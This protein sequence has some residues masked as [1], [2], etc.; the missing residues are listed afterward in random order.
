M[1]REGASGDSGPPES[2]S[3][4]DDLGSWKEVLEKVG[5]SAALSA[6]FKNVYSTGVN[7]VLAKTFLAAFSNHEEALSTLMR[8]GE[9]GLVDAEPLAIALTSLQTDSPPACSSG[10]V[11]YVDTH[12]FLEQQLKCYKNT[13]FHFYNI[14][15]NIIN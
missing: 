3:S 10:L 8:V 5:V 2:K 7:A 14:L 15:Y 4:P 6:A 9:V 12:S 1:F 13:L 11:G